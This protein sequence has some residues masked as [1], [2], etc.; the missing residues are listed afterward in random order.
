MKANEWKLTFFDSDCFMLRPFYKFFNQSD[1]TFCILFCHGN[2]DAVQKDLPSK[3]VS[4][5]K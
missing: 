3:I 1:M 5:D 4:I 2:T